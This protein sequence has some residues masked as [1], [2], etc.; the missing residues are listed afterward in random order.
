MLAQQTKLF[1][2]FLMNQELEYVHFVYKQNKKTHF[3]V[4]FL[5]VVYELDIF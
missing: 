5:K 4:S 1:R 2:I 3:H